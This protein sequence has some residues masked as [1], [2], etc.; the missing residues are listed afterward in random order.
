MIAY[1]AGNPVVANLLMLILVIGGIISRTRLVIR[2]Y[3][4]I[5]IH[6]VSV[7][8]PFPGDSPREVEEDI[9]RRSRRR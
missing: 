9:N 4:K 1:F 2:Q 7:F 5:N 8:A 3:T 6:M